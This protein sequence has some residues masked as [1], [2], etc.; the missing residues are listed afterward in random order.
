MVT[1][2]VQLFHLVPERSAPTD[3]NTL[4]SIRGDVNQQAKG[5]EGRPL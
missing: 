1:T 5:F 3:E 4:G 2:A